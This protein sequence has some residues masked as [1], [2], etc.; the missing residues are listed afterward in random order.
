MKKIIANL[1]SPQL[2]LQCIRSIP[3]RIKY[4]V[5]FGFLFFTFF[6]LLIFFLF[7]KMFRLIHKIPV[8]GNLLGNL[9]SKPG[10]LLDP[11]HILIINKLESWR[12]SEVKRSYLIYLAFEN[13]RARKTRSLVTVLGMSVG[14]GIIVLLISLGY[15]IEKLVISRVASLDELKMV[16]VS[17][18]GSTSLRLN[19]ETLKKIEK[20]S[21]VGK[22]I[23]FISFVGKV[24]YNRA[25]TDV[26]VYAAPRSYLD[27]SKVKLL[28]GKLFASNETYLSYGGQVAG[29]QTSVQKGVLDSLISDN[30]LYF[31]IVPDEVATVWSACTVSSSVIGYAGRIEGGYKGKEYWGGSYYP[32]D[33]KG[34][35][36]YDPEQAIY[37]GKWIQATVPLFFKTSDGKLGP[38][39]DKEGIQKWEKGC[40]QEKYT[41]VMDRLR[42]ASVLGESTESAS[43]TS[44]A[45]ASTSLTAS[46]SAEATD[47]ATVVYETVTV[48]TSSGGLE[49]VELSASSSATQKKQKD[50]YKFISKP[51]GQAIVSLGFLNLLNIPVEKALNTKFNVSFIVTKSLVPEVEGK[52]L[53]S[54]EEYQI[55]GVSDDAD[56]QHFYVP[57]TDIQKIGGT[58]FT[59]LKVILKDKNDIAKVRKSIET[60]GFRTTSTVDTVA[61]IESLF[62]NLRIVLGLLGMVALGV[63]SLGMFNTLTVSLLERTREIGGMKTMGMVSEE[64]QDLFLAEAMI[65]GLSGGLG[66]LILGYLIGNGLSFL[67]STIAIVK[68]QGYLELTYVPPQFVLFIIVSSF[69]VGL[70]TGLYPAQRAKKISALNALRYE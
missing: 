7:E 61:Q 39:L 69:I 56:S 30:D 9:F 43:L 3:S 24:S 13:L 28:K 2:I 53:T 11:Y 35:A 41:Q 23:P 55:L 15:G 59:Q 66:G 19:N 4:L 52:A 1:L 37:L 45:S 54:E 32:F 51:S 49:V 21:S 50:T 40:I 6:L 20:L 14:V 64:V 22:A 12:P 46:S 48:S 36:A 29:A 17:T 68:G 62:A 44:T 5:K 27:F 10:K 16:D 47:S 26:L 70:V 67:V 33:E 57:F 8:M 38:I 65:M 18:G 25:N 31:N 34:K 58:N 42:F 60:M 63:A